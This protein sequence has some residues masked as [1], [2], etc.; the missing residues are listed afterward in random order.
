MN[1]FKLT[2]LSVF[3]IALIVHQLYAKYPEDR[4][5]EKLGNVSKSELEQKSYFDTT[6]PDAIILFDVGSYTYEWRGDAFKTQFERHCRIKILKSSGFEWATFQIPL[7]VGTPQ[8][9]ETLSNI[10]GYT[11]VLENGKV[12]S[13]KLDKSGIFKDKFSDNVDLVKITLPNVVEGSIVEFSYVISS[14]R[15]QS[16]P[17]WE[18][19]KNIPVVWSEYTVAIPEFYEFQQ[20]TQGYESF[21][22]NIRTVENSALNF[23]IKTERSGNRVVQPSTHQQHREDYKVNKNYF[24]AKHL[25]GL[26]HEKFI[27]KADDYLLKIEHQI[28]GRRFPR[29]PYE[30]LLGDWNKI[31]SVLLEHS[32]FGDQIKPKGFYKKDLESV[33]A[34]SSGDMETMQRIYKHISTHMKWNGKNA[35]FTEK[36]IKSAYDNQGGNA[37]DINL[38]LVSML[39]SAGLSAE[40]V[41]LST[42][43]NGIINPNFVMLNKYNYVVAQVNID[44]E[45]YLLDATEPHLPCN[46]LPIRCLNQHGRIIN[47]TGG[48]WV[49]LTPKTG[50]ITRSVSIL[51][52]QLDGTLEGTIQRKTEGYNGLLCS[53]EYKE[54]GKEKY[55]E[56]L[57]E[58]HPTWEIE[59]LTFKDS[60]VYDGYFLE[61]IK[62]KIK[63]AGQIM[64]KTIYIDPFILDKL[65][66]NPFKNDKRKLPIDM[67]MPS[68]ELHNLSI[69]LPEGFSIDET[70]I[71]ANLVSPDKSTQYKVLSNSNGNIF[72][73]TRTFLRN[74]SLYGPHEYDMLR[75]FYSIVVAKESEQ[76]V[77]QKNSL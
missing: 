2:L 65:D 54:K 76:L 57:K 56:R 42:R 47:S 63:N 60:D 15:T 10:K 49:D 67:V 69:A 35:L 41:I 39:N 25:P 53:Q 70:P 40:P 74:R 71:N 51:E 9:K 72:N 29:S 21:Y 36:N 28:A 55:L 46:M 24:A 13:H 68:S 31:N 22:A 43:S 32:E 16:I 34:N 50:G 4:P 17:A 77:L 52:L 20:V 75:E 62:V 45:I 61:T 5:Y 59:D 27:S 7:Y 14:D 6:D 11:H 33:T 1:T 48:G 3:G 19:Q 73:L 23:N 12:K 66:E 38:L 58:D 44:G 64:G 26:Q 37:A 30:N 18:F 8:S